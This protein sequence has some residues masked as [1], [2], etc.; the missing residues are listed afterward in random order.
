[1][2]LVLADI[3]RVVGRHRKT[4]DTDIVEQVRAR[5]VALQ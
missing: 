1:M 5:H 4:S 3:V 2:N